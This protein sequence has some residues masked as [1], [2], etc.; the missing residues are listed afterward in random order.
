MRPLII[1][2]AGGFGL[3]VATYV[4]DIGWQICGFLDDIKPAGHIHAGYPVL[5]TTDA[6]IDRSMLFILAVGLPEG[7]R[8]LAEKLTSKGAEFTTLVHPLAYHGCQ[9]IGT[10]S[11]IAPFAFTGPAARLGNHSIL[12]VHATAGHESVLGDYCVLS[13]YANVHGQATLGRGVFIGSNASVTAKIR[14]GDNSQ[15]AAGSVVYND[16]PAGAHVFGNPA[17]FKV[18]SE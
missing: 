2:G 16:T 14:I 18:R 5:G 17:K 13:P 12:N 1:V 4:R 10:G 7:R 11:I 9:T 3:E 6:A 8:L 15:I